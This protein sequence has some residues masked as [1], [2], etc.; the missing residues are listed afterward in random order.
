MSLDEKTE[1]DRLATIAADSWYAS[2]A[3]GASVR[4]SAKLLSRFWKGRR[5]LELGPAEGLI[6]ERLIEAFPQ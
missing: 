6:T 4:Y 5:C 1:L 3:N 2:G